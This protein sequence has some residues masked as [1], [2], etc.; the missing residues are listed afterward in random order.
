MLIQTLYNG[1]ST[2]KNQMLRKRFFFLRSGK[3]NA[4]NEVLKSFHFVL[5][6]ICNV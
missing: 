5:F 2:K 4:E 1:I 6:K 3:R